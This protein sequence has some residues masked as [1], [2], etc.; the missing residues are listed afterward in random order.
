M[1]LALLLILLISVEALPQQVP[2]TEKEL[3]RQREYAQAV[4][5]VEQTA[6]EAPLWDDKKSAVLALADAADLLWKQTPNAA[7]KWLTKAWELIDSVPEESLDPNLKEFFNR[8]NKTDLQSSVLR[9]AHTHDPALA[10]TFVKSLDDKEL[11][12]KKERGAFDDRTARSEQFLRLAQQAVNSNPDLAFALAQRSLADGLSFTLQDVLTGLR[13]KNVELSNRLFDLALARFGAGIPDPSEAEVLAGY[14]FQPGMTYSTN[15]AGQVIV[16]MNPMQQNEAVVAQS[17]PQRARAFL[18]AAYQ[19][20]LT[21]QVVVETPEAKT[22]AQKIWVFGTR[23]L[24]RYQ[25]HAPEFAGPA[26]DFLERLQAQIYPEGRGNPFSSNRQS[27][28]G[29]NTATKPRTD[30]EILDDRITALEA[31]AEKETDPAA[32]KLAYINAALAVEATDYERGKRIAEKIADDD[33]SAEVVSYVFYRAALTLVTKKEI[34]KALELAT[35]LGNLQRRSMVKLA[36]A[37]SLL[38]GAVDEKPA[39]DELTV[40]QQR[41]IDLLS[42][43]ERDIKK[44]GPSANTAKILLGRATLLGKLDKAQALLSLNDAV[45]VINRLETFDMNDPSAP[46]LGLRLSARSEA[47]LDSPR[48]GFSFRRALE[49]LIATEFENLAELAGR[50]SRK[51]VRGI[52]R[53]AVAKLYLQTASDSRSAAR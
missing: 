27:G 21:R 20:F 39:A 14:L 12:E 38:A 15:S 16:S 31:R 10:D 40:D 23:S 30:K 50:F 28:S 53:L 48:V 6:A 5:M 13:R 26:R 41:A 33:L 45:S 7:R 17:E 32:K 29:S 37:Q 44:E 47:L 51:E 49:P 1:K 25:T 42:D 46:R 36:I 24:S 43:V 18:V 2:T 22:R 8:S 4:S 52:G 34:D 19:A 11:T 9:V 35:K 3:K